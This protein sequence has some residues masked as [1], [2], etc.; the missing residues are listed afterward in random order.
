MQSEPK[1]PPSKQKNTISQNTKRAYSKPN[2]QL[3]KKLLSYNLVKVHLS[4]KVNFG[5][6]NKTFQLFRP[7]FKEDRFTNI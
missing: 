7:S 1:L 4:V 6:E 3:S 2:E 5:N